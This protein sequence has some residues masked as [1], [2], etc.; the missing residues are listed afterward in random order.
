MAVRLW[1]V[2]HPLAS[3]IIAFLMFRRDSVPREFVFRTA[4]I[5]DNCFSISRLLPEFFSAQF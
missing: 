2:A 3:W 1:H 4:V 5:V